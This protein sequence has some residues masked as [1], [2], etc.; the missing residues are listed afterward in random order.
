MPWAFRS[1][2]LGA[3]DDDVDRFLHI[4]KS[5]GLRLMVR[6]LTCD[7]WLGPDFEYRQSPEEPF[8]DIRSF[9]LALPYLRYFQNLRTLHL[10]FSEVCGDNLDWVAIRE[11]AAFRWWVL[12]T[13]F[14]C[15]AG[16][17]NLENQKKMAKDLKK[18]ISEIFEGLQ[19]AHDMENPSDY[20]GQFGAIALSTLTISN[21][22]DFND[23]RFTESEVFQ[24]VLSSPDLVDLKLYV[25]EAWEDLRISHFDD[26]KPYYNQIFFATLP[27]TWLTPSVTGNLRTL[28]LYYRHYWGWEPRMDFRMLRPVTGMDS[29]FPH[30]KVLAL[31]NYVLSH[32]WQIGWIASLGHKLEELYLDGC[33][34][35][36]EATDFEAGT[37]IEETVVGVDENGEEIRIDDSG[38]PAGP[39]QME[40]VQIEKMEISMRWHTVLPQWQEALTGLKVFRMGHGH[41]YEPPVDILRAGLHDRPYQGGRDQLIRQERVLHNEFRWFDRPAQDSPIDSYECEPESEPGPD[42]FIDGVG[43]SSRRNQVCE[44]IQWGYYGWEYRE[45]WVRE[46]DDAEAP[47]DETIDLDTAAYEAMM[48]TVSAR[49]I[50]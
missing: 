41:W 37:E 39:S 24:K 50:V 8:L 30:L 17:W 21:L 33:A 12:D 34:I 36:N 46:S 43:I 2:R 28:S 42:K 15:L 49:A 5:N 44:Y 3:V 14:H 11:P 6:E 7:T 18:R 48:A 32:E 22:A 16:S 45:H 10:R 13:V 26:E 31:G 29:A 1:V 19:D 38:Y 20:T 27:Q 35:M 25:A 9:M 47:E 4:A 23:K 40:T